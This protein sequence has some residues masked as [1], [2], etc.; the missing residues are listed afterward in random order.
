MR[1]PLTCQP[2]YTEL[3]SIN[4]YF[5][6]FAYAVSSTWNTLPCVDTAYSS[7]KRSRLYILHLHFVSPLRLQAGLG[8]PLEVPPASTLLITQYSFVYQCLFH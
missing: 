6:A 5:Q 2:S 3:H 7:F 8:S 4:A 1:P